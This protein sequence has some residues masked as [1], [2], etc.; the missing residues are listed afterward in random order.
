MIEVGGVQ[1]SV[2][3]P[4]T[5]GITGKAEISHTKMFSSPMAQPGR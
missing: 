1:G 5:E 2:K 3:A 4:T